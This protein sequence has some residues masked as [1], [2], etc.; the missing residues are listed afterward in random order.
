MLLVVGKGSDSRLTVRARRA[1]SIAEDGG[2]LGMQLACERT[3]N[4][5]NYQCKAIGQVRIVSP[6]SS[7]CYCGNLC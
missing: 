5:C 1:R 2:N 3:H 4:M 6:G 7:T